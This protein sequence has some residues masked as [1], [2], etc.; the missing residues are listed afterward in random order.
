MRHV[1]LAIG[2][3]AQEVIGPEA[4][5]FLLQA[6]DANTAPIYVG[7][8]YVTADAAAT[9]GYRLDAGVSLPVFSVGNEPLWAIAPSGS[10]SLRVLQGTDVP[11]VEVG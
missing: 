8:L 2:T 10:Q 4:G 11:T 3:A 1:T 7:A 9:G 6:D 5:G